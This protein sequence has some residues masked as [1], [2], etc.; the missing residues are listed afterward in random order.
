MNEYNKQLDGTQAAKPELSTPNTGTFEE[1]RDR[2]NIPEWVMESRDKSK[3]FYDYDNEFWFETPEDHDNGLS[4]ARA[5]KEDMPPSRTRKYDFGWTGSLRVTSDGGKD[6]CSLDD[7]GRLSGLATIQITGPLADDQINVRG[8]PG[9]L[10]PGSIR[11]FLDQFDWGLGI[12]LEALPQV[13]EDVRGGPQLIDLLQQNRLA[14]P[15]VNDERPGADVAVDVGHNA[16][17]GDNA[18]TPSGTILQHVLYGTCSGELRAI[19]M[20]VN[21]WFAA[22]DVSRLTSFEP[23]VVI[24][25][26]GK[27]RTV[28]IPNASIINAIEKEGEVTYVRHD[29]VQSLLEGKEWKRG[30]VHGWFDLFSK[31]LWGK[32]EL[33]ASLAFV[34]A[35]T[36]RRALGKPLD[37]QSLV[38]TLKAANP[39]FSGDLDP[40]GD[41]QIPIAMARDVALQE[42]DFAG[43]VTAHLLADGGFLHGGPIDETPDATLE[44]FRRLTPNC[45]GRVSLCK[46][47]EFTNGHESF[48]QW[49]LRHE[50]AGYTYQPVCEGMVS[51]SDSWCNCIWDYALSWSPSRFDGPDCQKQLRAVAVG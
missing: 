41:F 27:Y 22:D 30:W 5:Y 50:E 37:L 19:R 11:L 12:P 35:G 40:A 14:D 39:G 43:L 21:L 13:L 2:L 25:F 49:F 34:G 3:C 9:F 18:Q 28:G 31:D 33:P 47:W 24:Q 46:I 36:L 26:A 20:G 29:A 6:W 32:A 38:A 17:A 16:S 48:E 4:Q 7:A 51:P 44:R 23:Q 45:D 42:D 8:V 1:C 10:A 15:Y